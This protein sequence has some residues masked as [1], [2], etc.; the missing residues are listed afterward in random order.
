MLGCTSRATD[1]ASR[2]KRATNW[3][4]V[5]QVLGQQLD[6]HVALEAIVEGAH[7]G[8]HAA[9]AEALAQLVAAREDLAGHHGDRLPA[10]AVPPV[11]VSVP[12]RRAG[13]RAVGVGVG[14]R[15]V[16]VGPRRVGPGVR[17][18]SCRCRWSRFCRSV[19]RVR[20]RGRSGSV[21]C[22]WVCAWSHVA[23]TRLPRL[24]MPDCRRSRRS[25]STESGRSSSAF[26]ALAT[27]LLGRLAAAG[28]VVGRDLVQGAL[29]ARR[30]ARRDPAVA[31]AGDEHGRRR[32]QHER[33]ERRQDAHPH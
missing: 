18:W 2:R 8:R 7:D 10:D 22:V 5:G 20:A 24:L 6:G 32:A 23:G 14:A 19:V 33:G 1:S 27:A 15:A 9:D 25:A 31:A 29:Q 26:W 3:L 16:G 21:C 28:A 30:V 11:P 13:G 4:V 12:G 17:W